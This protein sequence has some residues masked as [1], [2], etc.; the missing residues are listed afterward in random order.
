MNQKIIIGTFQQ[1]PKFLK[2]NEYIQNGYVI[3]CISFKRAIRCLFL[4]HNETMNT[5]THLLGAIFFI[6]LFIYT[7]FFIKDFKIQ[8][9]IIKQDLPLIEQKSLILYEQSSDT[10]IIYNSIKNIQESFYHYIPK[11]IYSETIITFFLYITIQRIL[12]PP[13][14][15]QY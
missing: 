3:N 7:I 13:L 10:K 6:F 12:F 15:L 5:W 2:D 9:D 8:L 14:N 4:F 1:T 11:R